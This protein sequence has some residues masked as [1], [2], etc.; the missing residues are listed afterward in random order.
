MGSTNARSPV[1]IQNFHEFGATTL[2]GQKIQFS[3]YKGKVVLVLNVASLWDTTV[4]DYTQMNDLVSRFGDKLVILG[5]P[6]NQFKYQVRTRFFKF[7]IV[8][9]LSIRLNTGDISTCQVLMVHVEFDKPPSISMQ[10][11]GTQ[12]VYWRSSGLNQRQYRCPAC[13]HW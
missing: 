8:G 9:L 10:G 11:Q 12:D 6:C 13:R 2:K 3:S 7:K 1:K 5:F 4:R